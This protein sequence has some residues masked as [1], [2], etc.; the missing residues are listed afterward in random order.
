MYEKM[1]SQM[2]ENLRLRS[3]AK[4]SHKETDAYIAFMRAQ[5]HDKLQAAI[6]IP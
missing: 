2:K 1:S 6:M 4:H 5:Q 3:M